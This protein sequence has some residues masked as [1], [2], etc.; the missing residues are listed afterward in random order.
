M[1]QH[2]VLLKVNNVSYDEDVYKTQKLFS[3]DYLYL[4]I[5]TSLLLII[6]Y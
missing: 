4:L 2:L 3:Y 5:N 6:N 1:L